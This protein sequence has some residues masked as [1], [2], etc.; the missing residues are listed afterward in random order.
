MRQMKADLEAVGVQVKHP[1][2]LSEAEK[3]PKAAFP[4]VIGWIDWIGTVDVPDRDRWYLWDTVAKTL[5]TRQARPFGAG[6]ALLRLFR[7]PRLPEAYKWTVGSAL[8]TVADVSMLDDMVALTRDRTFGGARQM[9]VESL[10]R[11]GKG[12]RREE[13]ID[14]LMSVLDDDSVVAFA[15]SALAKLNATRA[16]DEI[17]RHLDSP[18]PIAKQMARNAIAKLTQ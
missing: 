17:A 7:D 13:V 5:A 3:V 11:L 18:I 10:G 12:P 4:V 6:P 2:H 15:I 8:Y 1:A 9:I 16:V 14:V